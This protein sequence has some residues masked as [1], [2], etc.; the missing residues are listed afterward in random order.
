MN[1]PQ[2]TVDS[3]RSMVHG[4]QQALHKKTAFSVFLFLLLWS[5]VC[6]PWTS[7]ASAEMSFEDAESKAAEAH[8]LAASDVIYQE[9]DWKALYYQNAQMISLLKDIKR[10][11][12][13][14]NANSAKTD[15]KTSF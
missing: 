9:Q 2:S 12:E 5:V 15:Q 13:T 6:G 7:L 4:P 11:L 8:K 14:L 1:S 3:P 10:E